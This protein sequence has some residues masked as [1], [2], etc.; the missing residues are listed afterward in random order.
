ML[1]AALFVAGASAYAIGYVIGYQN[2]K[3]DAIMKRNL[4]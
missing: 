2:G 1:V 3:H 4:P